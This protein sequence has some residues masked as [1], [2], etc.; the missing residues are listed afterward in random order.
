M[1]LSCSLTARATAYVSGLELSVGMS[2]GRVSDPYADDF[3]VVILSS[4]LKSLA[5]IYSPVDHV[6]CQVIR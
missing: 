4:L 3:V 6:V 2:F 1:L 5:P